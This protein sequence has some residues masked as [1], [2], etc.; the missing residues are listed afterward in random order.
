MSAALAPTPEFLTSE[1]FTPSPDEDMGF[2]DWIGPV[3]TGK[4]WK[5]TTNWTEETGVT[6]YVDGDGDNAIPGA[7]AGLSLIH[8]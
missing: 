1:G 5:V 4:G 6:F 7:E 2:I 3:F 8:I